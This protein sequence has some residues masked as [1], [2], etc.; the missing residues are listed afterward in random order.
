MP[1]ESRAAVGLF[2]GLGYRLDERIDERND[3]PTA[4]EPRGR[5]PDRACAP[6]G[7]S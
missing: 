6:T 2:G 4:E 1:E 7:T 3:D 5:L